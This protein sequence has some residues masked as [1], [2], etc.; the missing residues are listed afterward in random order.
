M[1]KYLI[2]IGILGIGV[3]IVF[4]VLGNHS[5]FDTE[6]LFG[7][8]SFKP[9]PE[10]IRQKHVTTIEKVD[11]LIVEENGAAEVTSRS[12]KFNLENYLGIIKVGVLPD[13]NKKNPNDPFMQDVELLVEDIRKY[14]KDKGRK[15][16]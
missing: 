15:N 1:N 9:F 4:L 8:G 12:E 6:Y 11:A 10:E 3:V 16:Y 13:L 7:W 14:I 2:V 5:F